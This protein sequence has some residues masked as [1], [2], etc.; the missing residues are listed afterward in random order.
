MLFQDHLYQVDPDLPSLDGLKTAKPGWYLGRVSHGRFEPSQ[1]F[2]M[3][4]SAE[5]M[6]QRLSLAVDDPMVMRYLKG[7]TLMLEGPKG[8]TLVCLEGYPLG[9]AKQT[10]DYLKNHYP[11]GWRQGY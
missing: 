4:L 5:Q 11:P 2:A 6:K 10:G 1:A 7:E 3:G 9:F 8:W